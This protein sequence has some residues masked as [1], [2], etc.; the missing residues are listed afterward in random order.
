MSAFLLIGSSF[1]KNRAGWPHPPDG[2]IALPP[3]GYASECDIASVSP[4]ET[5]ER[6]DTALSSGPATH[7]LN[8]T[9]GLQKSNTGLSGSSI[10]SGLVHHSSATGSTQGLGLGKCFSLFVREAS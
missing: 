9:L 3:I 7:L 4:N 5:V 1:K 6:T 2:G 10:S 8:V